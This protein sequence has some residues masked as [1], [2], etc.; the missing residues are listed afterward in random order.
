M[1][2][3]TIATPFDIRMA[4]ATSW[5]KANGSA[6]GSV[7][8]NT[9]KKIWRPPTRSAAVSLFLFKGSDIFLFCH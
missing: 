3:R 2:K 7:H 4:K 1:N 9:N 6:T 8:K 5:K